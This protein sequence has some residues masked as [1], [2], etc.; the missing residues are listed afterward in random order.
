MYWENCVIGKNQ[1]SKITTTIAKDLGYKN[2]KSFTT[3]SLRRS[4]ATLF[5]ELGVTVEELQTL[6]NWKSAEI[7]CHYVNHSDTARKRIAEKVFSNPESKRTICNTI[8][9]NGNYTFN[10]P[11]NIYNNSPG[12]SHQI[13]NLPFFS[14]VTNNNDFAKLWLFPREINGWNSHFSKGK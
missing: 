5:T 14:D 8:F 1:F 3:H 12:N 13:E 7:A 9:G 6:G 4:G 10:A 2:Y 11:V